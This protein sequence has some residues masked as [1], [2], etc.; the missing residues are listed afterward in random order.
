MK[1]FRLSCLCSAAVVLSPHVSLATAF[2]SVGYQINGEA[3]FTGS[4]QP[5]FDVHLLD[6]TDPDAEITVDKVLGADFAGGSA[7]GQ[8]TPR[9]AQGS[10]GVF[11]TAISNSSGYLS[12]GNATVISKAQMRDNWTFTT[13]FQDGAPLHVIAAFKLD[14]GQDINLNGEDSQGGYADSVTAIAQTTLTVSGV[15]VLPGPYLNGAYAY[16]YRDV[17]RG[18][19][20]IYDGPPPYVYFD[21]VFQSG[22]PMSMQFNLE[23]NQSVSVLSND[24]YRGGSAL[25]VGNF[26]H[27]L[28]WDGITS[29]TDEFGNP[30]S[31]WT[32]TTESGVDYA[33]AIQVPEPST[34]VILLAAIPMTF[35]LRRRNST[36]A[37]QPSQ[38]A[39]ADRLRSGHTQGPRRTSS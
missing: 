19:N 36:V 24:Y 20:D 9:A 29:V 15:G 25:A 27:T 33:H 34:A 8:A 32:L 3:G 6:S 16:S 22:V 30:V 11:A 17:N 28:I 2:E 39:A 7:S 37:T 13:G 12:Y 14:G 10:L 4:G 21:A 18:D 1:W 38:P 23:L 5:F 26:S 35:L 31:D